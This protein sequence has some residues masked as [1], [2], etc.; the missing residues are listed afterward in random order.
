MLQ[1][2]IEFLKGVV[3]RKTEAHSMSVMDGP[4][5]PNEALD[6]CPLWLEG[7][8]GADDLAMVEGVGLC[9]SDGNQVL[10]HPGPC[11]GDGATLAEFDAPIS[12]L[13]AYDGG[14]LIV[15]LAGVGVTFYS[16]HL[17]GVRVVE[18]GGQ[19]IRCPTAALLAPDG[20]VYIAEGST[21]NLPERWV[22]DLMGKQEAGRLIQFDPAS[23]STKVILDRLAY[24]HG[25]A[26]A[27]DGKSL[28]VT[29]S[30]RHRV[31]SL[32]LDA[33]SPGLADD[34]VKRLPGYPARITR[35]SDGGYWLALFALRTQLVEFILQEDDFRNEMIASVQPEFWAAPMLYSPD[36]YLEPLQG[37]GLKQLGVK[38]P[39]APP[40]SYGLVAKLDGDLN[41]T[42]TWHSRAGRKRHGIAKICETPFGAFALSKGNGIILRVEGEARS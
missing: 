15:C 30:W 18:A 25:L 34:P 38:K 35:S 8:Q 2:A 5:L 42:E 24:P 11:A 1:P 6:R 36:Y 39:W 21:A 33:A 19:P 41:V 16:G 27:H 13:A 23:G 31:R 26:A 9:V 20:K 14:G 12:G 37:G 29:E 17:D 3:F 32:R 40:R 4:W 10:T 28:L 7:I 22:H